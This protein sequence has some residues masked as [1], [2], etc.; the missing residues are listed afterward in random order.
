MLVAI[1][2]FGAEVSPRFCF[3]RH[4]LVA[5]LDAAGD[6]GTLVPLG[7][8]GYPARLRLLADRGVGLLI[9]GGFQ[10]SFLP[11]AEGVGIQ[12]V[13]GIAGPVAAALA[14]ARAGR[15]PPPGAGRRCRCRRTGCPRF[16]CRPPGGQTSK[17]EA[18]HVRKQNRCRGL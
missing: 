16:P 8:P 17:E 1:A 5:D 7:P 6:E 10:R 12:V 9:C 18:T 13:W 4:V 14:G 3:A 11:V 15:L 2:T